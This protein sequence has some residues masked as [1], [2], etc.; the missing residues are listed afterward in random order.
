MQSKHGGL[1]GSHDG[2]RKRCVPNSLTQCS[3]HVMESTVSSNYIRDI[4]RPS[5]PEKEV[6]RKENTVDKIAKGR[7]IRKSTHAQIPILAKVLFHYVMFC[8]KENRDLSS[9][10]YRVSFSRIS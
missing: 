7:Q 3:F 1:I 9:K 2:H 10:I 4:H 8:D 5:T 6:N